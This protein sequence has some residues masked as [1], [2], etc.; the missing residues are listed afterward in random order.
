MS[1][2]SWKERH[3][4]YDPATEL[5]SYDQVAARL[6]GSKRTLERYVRDGLI[7]SI[8]IGARCAIERC[9]LDDFFARE[10]AEAS[11]RRAGRAKAARK[12][13]SS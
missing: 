3:V 13:V 9:E 2:V 12:R 5:L 6:R 4:N 11:R 1:S 7:A 8:K 10:R